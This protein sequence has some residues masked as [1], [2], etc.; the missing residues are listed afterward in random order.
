VTIRPAAVYSSTRRSRPVRPFRRRAGIV[1]AIGGLLATTACGGGFENDDSGA[2]QQEGPASLTMLIAGEP[3]EADAVKKAAAAWAA[4]SG[5]KVEVL[6][7]QDIGQQLAQGFAGGKPP[8]VFYVDAPRFGDL[9]KAGSLYAYADQIENIDEY[10]PNL[11]KTFT[12][13]GKEYCV[14]KDFSTLALQI[15]TA[16]WAQAGL[17]D[18]D[19]PTTWAELKA[20]ALKL[21]KGN[22]AGLVV[23]DTRDRL[24]A[25]MRQAGGWTLS[26]DGTRATADTPE[27]LAALAYWKDLLASGAARY[28]S[29]VDAGWGGE[30]FGTQRAAMTIEG[31]WLRGAMRNDY[32]EVKYT[33]H[34]LPAGPKGKGTL[35]FTQC[36]GVAQ[37]SKAKTQAV[38]L[39]KALLSPEQ[40]LTNAEQFGVM[41]ALKSANEEY[42]KNNPDDAAFVTGAEYAQGPVSAPGTENVLKDFDAKIQGI[43]KADPAAILTALQ[44]NLTSALGG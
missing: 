25:F 28:P 19:V 5:N 31:N 42:V 40:Q 37:Q 15:N 3:R 20:V 38:D 18:A 14:P 23:G 6:V 44:A 33:V 27:N 24:G 8:D 21:N 32:P 39:V 41:P 29:G 9:A 43:L 4:K 2:D 16:A 1:L 7:A 11:R 17:T 12:Y 36:Y 13:D 10:Y 22:R 30:A 34:E 26:S 35:S